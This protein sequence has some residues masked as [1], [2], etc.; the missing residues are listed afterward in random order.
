MSSNPLPDHSGSVRFRTRC[1][2]R[3]REDMDMPAT[4][5]RTYPLRF[6]ECTA[7]ERTFTEKHPT[8]NWRFCAALDE[9]EAKP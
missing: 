9:E 6:W 8:I 7:C 1:S 2:I 4:E 5:T 3:R